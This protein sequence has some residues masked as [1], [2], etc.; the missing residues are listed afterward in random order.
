MLKINIFITMKYFVLI[1]FLLPV[2]GFIDTDEIIFNSNDGKIKITATNQWKAAGNMKGVEIYISRENNNNTPCTVVISKDI[3]LLEETDL[4][5]YSAGKLF[6][7]TAVL[8]TSQPFIGE[9]SIS[10][11]KFKYYEY[12]YD[13]KNLIKMKTLVYHALSGTNGYQMTITSTLNGFEQKRPLY[14]QIA[15]SI[16]LIN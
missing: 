1:I 16:K 3:N 5:T 8:K 13:N 9:K 14:N 11:V 12:E 15:N 10:G 2:L 7:Q 4:S 6:L